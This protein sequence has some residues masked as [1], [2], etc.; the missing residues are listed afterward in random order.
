M[1][2]LSSWDG[3]N[4]GEEGWLWCCFLGKP[5]LLNF[6]ALQTPGS[7]EAAAVAGDGDEGLGQGSCLHLGERNNMKTCLCSEK[8]PMEKSARGLHVVIVTR[9]LQIRFPCSQIK[10]FFR[11]LLQQSLGPES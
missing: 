11:A 4:L 9:W 1:F 2:P 5:L 3:R 8:K 6:A 10:L 7:R